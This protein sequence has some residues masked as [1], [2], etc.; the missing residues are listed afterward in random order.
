MRLMLGWMWLTVSGNKSD[1]VGETIDVS[2]LINAEDKFTY[3]RDG[4]RALRKMDLDKLIIAVC[5]PF[6]ILIPFDRT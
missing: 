6:S 5:A 4:L 1:N 3:V 2:E